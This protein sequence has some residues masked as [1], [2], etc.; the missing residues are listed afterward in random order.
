MLPQLCNAEQQVSDFTQST[1]EKIQC[2]F[3][4]SLCHTDLTGRVV[5]HLTVSIVVIPYIQK[6][7]A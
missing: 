5:T 2:A 4:L 6:G 3:M 7:L 1:Y